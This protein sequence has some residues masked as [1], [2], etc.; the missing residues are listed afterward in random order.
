MTNVDWTSPSRRK[1]FT[2]IE[3]LIVV[4]IIAILAAIAIPSYQNYVRRGNRAA[5]QS[6]LMDV[7]SKQQQYLM[8]A[9][10]FAPDVATLNLAVPNTVTPFYTVTITLP[11]N[12][13]P[14]SFTVTATPI[15]GTLQAS[16]YTLTLDNTG[17]KGPAGKW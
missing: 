13:T 6:F 2:L 14:P 9:R 15:A 12:Q 11:A 10:S 7:A 17:A 8:D 16:D 3:V 5:A 1:G 4:G